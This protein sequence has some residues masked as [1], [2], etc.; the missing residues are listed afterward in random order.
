MRK[1]LLLFAAAALLTSSGA[2]VAK[3]V[4]VTITKNGYVPNSLSIATGDTVQF[5]NGDTAAHQVDFKT[6]TGV[7][8]TPNPLVIQPAASG[9]CTFATAGSYTYSDPNF[10]GNTYRGSIT[11]VAPPE[12]LTL[13]V[14]PVLVVF[15]VKVALSGALSTQKVGVPIDVYGQQ[16]GSNAAS[17]LATVAT[18]TGGAFASAGQPLMNTTYTAKHQN[19]SSPAVAV[20]VRPAVRLVKVAAHRFSIR[21]SAAQSFAGKYAGFQRYNGTLHRWVAV[22]AVALKAGTAGS[23]TILSAV[24]FRTTLKA[25]FQVRAALPQAQVGGC[26]AAGLSNTIKS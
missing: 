5:T 7:T 25:G 21:V 11:V 12:S 13:A 1:L 24:T 17:K 2:A 15:G 23:P 8:C 4:T 16:C 14:K 18:T 19:T 26:Y 10:K 20:R 9:S 22:K 6:T 3:T